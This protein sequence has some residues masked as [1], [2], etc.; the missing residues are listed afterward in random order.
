[1]RFSSSVSSLI[2]YDSDW[3]LVFS[4]LG[5]RIRRLLVDLLSF[6]RLEGYFDLVCLILVARMTWV[7]T[8]G[9]PARNLMELVTNEVEPS[10]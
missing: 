4:C 9:S 7:M 8:L 5:S 10:V 3:N 1:M 6:L 2:L